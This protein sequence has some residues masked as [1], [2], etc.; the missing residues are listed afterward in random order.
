MNAHGRPSFVWP[1]YPSPQGA[2]V[3][4]DSIS[5]LATSRNLLIENLHAALDLA[6]AE[7]G[8]LVGVHP[9]DSPIAADLDLYPLGTCDV[10][11]SAFRL[12]RGP[13]QTDCVRSKGAF[14]G[15]SSTANRLHQF[16]REATTSACHDA[17]AQNR[18]RGF[19]IEQ[20]KSIVLRFNRHAGAANSAG[21][22]KTAP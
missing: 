8:A 2:R 9:Q 18:V 17:L 15:G 13:V 19:G 6:D 7:R 1:P 5:R 22:S 16:L 10:E 12:N 3:L 21:A 14:P 20:S 11:I 4:D